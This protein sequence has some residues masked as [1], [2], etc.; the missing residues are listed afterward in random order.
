MA[1]VNLKSTQLSPSSNPRLPAAPVEYDSGYI[2]SLTSIL[3][4]YFNQIDNLTQSLLTNT[5]MRFLRAPTGSFYDNTTQSTTANTATLL[6]FGGTDTPGT[7]AITM[8]GAAT[9][10]FN[11]SISGTTLTV[12]AVSSP[13]TNP[14]YVGMTITGTGISAGTII[15]ALQSVGGNGG[16]GTYTVNNSQT[17][18]STT[19]SGSVGQRMIFTYPGVYNLQF[20]IQ[21]DNSDTAVQDISIWLRQ[22]GIDIVGSTGLISVPSSHGGV[23]GHGIFGWNFFLEV[24]ASDCIQMYWSTTNTGVTI[25]NYGTQT[26][27]VRPST[28]SV[29]ATVTF[30]SAPLT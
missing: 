20:S 17:V 30:V 5:G 7:N 18:S 1:L 12:T 28:Y 13:T 25:K 16:T 10:S 3:R 8:A 15:T 2:N 24:Q 23:N 19:I 22:N 4:Q 9:A 6:A 14:I 27:P 11:G 26:G 21:A 29:V